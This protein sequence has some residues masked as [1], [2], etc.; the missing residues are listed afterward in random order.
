MQQDYFNDKIYQLYYDEVGKHP[1]LSPAEERKLLLRYHTCPGCD[2]RLPPRIEVKNC[3]S[4]GAIA[5]LRPT[6]KVFVCM[7]CDTKFDTHMA[8]RMCPLCGTHRD[9]EAR[10]RLVES[11]LRFVIRR[12][13]S[14]TTKPEHLRKLVSA[15]NVGLMLA[16][17]K[18]S[19]D[20]ETRFL[21]YAEWWI[22]K[23]MFDEIH[24]SSFIHVPTHRQKSLRKEQKEGKYVCQ[25]CGLRTDDP[26]SK[27]H[28]TGCTDIDHEFILPLNNDSAVLND[29]VSLEDVTL[30]SNMDVENMVIDSDVEEHLRAAIQQMELSERDR[31]IIMGYFNVPLPDRKSEPKSLHQLAA[32]TGITPERVRQIKE[33]TLKALKKELKRRS[34]GNASAV[35]A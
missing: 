23:E 33:E 13:K 30:A 19:L 15:G 21:T 27:E 9:F 22:R 4:C 12:A 25:H 18:F 3:P 34:I 7:D 1:I 28:W 29:T 32:L 31:F 14:I 20:R 5:P 35:C 11:N 10:Q 26:E 17:D 6:G 8:P 16:I 2:K 24:S